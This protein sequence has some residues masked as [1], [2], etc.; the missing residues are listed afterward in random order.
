[1]TH[2]EKAQE[3]D[4]KYNVSVTGRHVQVTEAMKTYAIEKISKL[5]RIAPRIIDVHVTMDIQKVQHKVD[6]VMKYSNTTIKSGA[7]SNDMYASIDL[8]VHK[9]ESQLKRYLSRIH[10]HHAKNHQMVEIAET[11]YE[12]PDIEEFNAEIEFETKEKR[13]AALRPG[14]IVGTEKQ[15]LKVLTPEE[16][17]MKMDLSKKPCMVFRGEADRKLKVIYRRADG[18]F[19]IIEAE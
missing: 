15:H 9:L 16:A 4:Q 3:L 5:E 17:V 1:M 14:Q 2:K 7:V 13:S 12:A 10:D 6:I 18:N 11:I 19:G 8:A